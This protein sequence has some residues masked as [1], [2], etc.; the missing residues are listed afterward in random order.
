MKITNNIQQ[1]FTGLNGYTS[2]TTGLY[3]ESTLKASRNAMS[4][5]SALGS[6]DL[7][8]R[9]E[10]EFAEEAT[11]K[12]PILSGNLL[13][14]AFKEEKKTFVD[15]LKSIFNPYSLKEVLNKIEI[16]VKVVDNQRE[17]EEKIYYAGLEILKKLSSQNK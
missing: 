13:V 4:R 14:Y 15:I 5:L 11:N 12:N 10:A 3:S 9:V 17:M 8:M 1:S 6:D 16:P 2:L 7:T